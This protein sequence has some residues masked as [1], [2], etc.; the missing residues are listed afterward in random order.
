MFQWLRFNVSSSLS[1]NSSSLKESARV[2]QTSPILTGLFKNPLMIPYRFDEDG[3]QLLAL[4]DVE[5]LGVSNPVAVSE[6]F[7]AK[8]RNNQFLTNFR[9]EADI[10]RSLNS[11]V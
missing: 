1:S 3:N 2:T 7:F 8:N 6:G 4:Q 11:T 9:I 10:S 5:E